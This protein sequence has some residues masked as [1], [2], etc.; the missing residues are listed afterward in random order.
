MEREVKLALEAA[1][2]PEWIRLLPVGMVDLVDGRPP[3]EVDRESLTT[4]VAEFEARGVDLVVDY[5]H[6]SLQGGRAPAAGWIKELEARDDGLWARVE[7]TAQAQEYLRQKEYRYFS[8]VLRLDPETR[9][10][11][12]LMQVALTNVPAMKGVAPLVAKYGGEASALSSAVSATG[13]EDDPTLP[14]EEPK[15]RW[16]QAPEAPEKALWREARELFRELATALGLAEGAGVAEVKKGLLALKAGAA[17]AEA[18][19][20]ELESLKARLTEEQSNRIVREALKAG[21]IS[22]AQK[23]W[24]LE[25]CR[26]D[27][28]GFGDF[29]A[30]APQV[31]PV[32]VALELVSEGQTAKGQL[33]PEEMAVCRA[34]NLRPEEY[35]KAKKEMN[36][37]KKTE[38]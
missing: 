27:P 38:G 9:R 18:L 30:K 35:L 34:A 29:V 16:G 22:P 6:Q 17:Q 24:A 25:Y 10:P 1:D 13:G 2:L 21:K 11:L 5:E 28:E 26:R 37:R 33:T 19:R 36:Q 8:P 3:V 23:G 32:G 20:A 15:G 14:A 12:A 4:L 7:W 31:V